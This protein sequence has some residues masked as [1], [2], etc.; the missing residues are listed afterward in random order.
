[1]DLVNG[2]L[3]HRCSGEFDPSDL[4]GEWVSFLLGQGAGWP[5]RAVPETQLQVALGPS[6]VSGCVHDAAFLA[7]NQ[8]VT[9]PPFLYPQVLSP[10]DRMGRVL[11]RCRDFLSMGVREVWLFDPEPRRAYRALPDGSLLH[12]PEILASAG[13]P[14]T[15]NVLPLFAVLDR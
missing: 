15:L 6:R 10:E 8:I 1:M 9:E 7:A 3:E 12:E 11:S 5:I 2:H 13:T 4:Q 14:I